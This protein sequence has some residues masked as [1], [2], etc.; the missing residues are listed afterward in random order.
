M[1]VSR[2]LNRALYGVLGGLTGRL[3]DGALYEGLA[4]CSAPN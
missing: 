1:L 2:R 4:S 3:L